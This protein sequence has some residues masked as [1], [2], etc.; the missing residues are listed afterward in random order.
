MKAY[1][2]IPEELLPSLLK[3]QD[4]KFNLFAPD[5]TVRSNRCIGDWF[6]ILQI[7]NATAG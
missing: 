7:A 2:V 4:T 5:Y 1:L 6:V 3:V